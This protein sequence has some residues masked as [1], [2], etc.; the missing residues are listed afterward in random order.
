MSEGRSGSRTECIC[1][2]FA[3][4]RGARKR[5][6]DTPQ[7]PA[8]DSAYAQR[9]RARERYRK[10]ISLSTHGDCG[11]TPARENASDQRLMCQGSHSP[12]G[13]TGKLSGMR[14]AYTCTRPTP[15]C[16]SSSPSTP[17]ANAQLVSCLAWKTVLGA[18]RHRE[19]CER[20]SGRG[21]KERGQG[22]TELAQGRL[23]SMRGSWEVT[24]SHVFGMGGR[25]RIH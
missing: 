11:I 17:F 12:S 21:G 22:E 10:P 7:K 3:E 2:R 20:V 1:H 5:D 6:L 24:D 18:K 8:P 15:Y 19:Q 25:Q 14:D 9:K 13:K 23:P 4:G 16:D